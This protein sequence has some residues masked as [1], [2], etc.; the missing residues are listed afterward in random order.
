MVQ[1]SWMNS[2]A[3]TEMGNA[4]GL[5]R[6]VWMGGLHHTSAGFGYRLAYY[7][8]FFVFISSPY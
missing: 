8:S 6:M 4:L 1:V 3:I 2:G 7:L 5:V